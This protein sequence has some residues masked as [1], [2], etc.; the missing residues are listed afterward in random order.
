MKINEIIKKKDKELS[1]DL[2]KLQANL[3]K[4][5]FEVASRETNKHTEIAKVKRDIARVKTILR[6]RE[7]SREETQDEK[8]S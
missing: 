1:A 7:I 4:L 8:K 5:R 3:T 2:G 6:E